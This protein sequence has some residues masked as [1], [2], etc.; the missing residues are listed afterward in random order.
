M[1]VRF[2]SQDCDYLP[3]ERRK[4]AAWVKSTAAEEGFAIGEIAYVFCSSEYHLGINR[5]YLGHD[6]NTDVITFDYNDPKHPKTISGDI[7]IDPQTVRE[8]ADVWKTEPNE[9]MHRVIIHG[10]LHLCGYKDKKTEEAEKM[11][12]RENHYLK[13]LQEIE[14]K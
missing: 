14:K 2:Y 9:E 6:Y 5:K 13:R 10:I 12:E 1:A 4:I 8:Y 3:A 11:R 7:F